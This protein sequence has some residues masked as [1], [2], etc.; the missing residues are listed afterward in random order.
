MRKQPFVKLGNRRHILYF[1]CG[2]GQKKRMSLELS[3]QPARAVL[4]AQCGGSS[5]QWAIRARDA[6]AAAL[7]RRRLSGR[8]LFQ[9]CPLY[10]IKSLFTVSNKRK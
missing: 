10:Y 5:L 1:F 6:Y 4:L 2:G 3:S 7:V 9:K 8:K